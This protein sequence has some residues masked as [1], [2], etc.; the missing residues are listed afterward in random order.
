MTPFPHIEQETLKKLD[1]LLQAVRQG[2]F[3]DTVKLVE[4][5]DKLEGSPP[6]K[7]DVSTLIDI[8]DDLHIEVEQLRK[9]RDDLRGKI[10]SQDHKLQT[11]ESNMSDVAKAL[12]YLFEPNPLE[13]AYDLNSIREFLQSKGMFF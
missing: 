13:K 9:D 12:R 10:I 5:V 2:K 3:D 1:Y 4:F 11:L 6:V 7:S 8:I